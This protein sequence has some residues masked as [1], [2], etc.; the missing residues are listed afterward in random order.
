MLN[1]SERSRAGVQGPTGRGQRV[2]PAAA[3]TTDVLLGPNDGTGPTRPQLH[4]MGVTA[5]GLY[6]HTV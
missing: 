5:L 4:G 3:V 1:V 6:P 2:T